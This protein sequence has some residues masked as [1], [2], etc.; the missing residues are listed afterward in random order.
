MGGLALSKERN[1]YGDDCPT[2]DFVAVE[3]VAADGEDGGGGAG[4]PGVVDANELLPGWLT[5]SLL[6]PERCRWWRK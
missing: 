1:G 2:T 6:Q 5:W 4:K 3:D